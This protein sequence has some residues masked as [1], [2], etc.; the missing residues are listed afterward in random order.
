[1]QRAK[2]NFGGFHWAD[3]SKLAAVALLVA[4]CFPTRT[5]AQQPGQKI[6]S[7]AQEATDALV[8]A[9]SRAFGRS[10]P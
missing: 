1:M 2:L 3:L 4:G 6:F 8:A 9:A 7:T 5:M 10:A